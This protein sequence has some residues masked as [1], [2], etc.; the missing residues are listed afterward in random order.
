NGW[1]R[2]CRLR[3][4]SSRHTAGARTD[5]MLS[6][7]YHPPAI[8]QVHGSR[9]NALLGLRECC[10]FRGVEP[11]PSCIRDLFVIRTHFAYLEGNQHI[12]LYRRVREFYRN[13]CHYYC[14][15]DAND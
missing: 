8:G 3:S 15:L 2:V 12:F 10:C 13:L 11:W 6:A 4:S 9:G 7:T 14:I 5:H 1:L